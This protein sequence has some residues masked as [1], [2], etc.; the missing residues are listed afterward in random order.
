M[1]V[2]ER[3]WE[4][5]DRIYI[6]ATLLG[7]LVIWIAIMGMLVLDVDVAELFA[8]GG[9]GGVPGVPAGGQLNPTVTITIYGGE[10]PDGRFGF[11]FSPDDLSTPGP[12]IRVKQGDV[13]KVVFINIGKLRHG[14][15]VTPTV[16]KTNPEVLFNAI[17]GPAN[18][19][20]PPEGQGSIVFVADQAGEFFYQCPVANHGPK[21]MWGKF[22]VEP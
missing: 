4:V 20:I 9:G 11:G 18:D 14:F 12:E 1:A 10:L 16:S 2:P 5:L 15:V 13:V 8:G 21:G 7:A 3:V 19:P 22:I 17:V 6:P